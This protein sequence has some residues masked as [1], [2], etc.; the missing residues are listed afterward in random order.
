MEVEESPYVR[1]VESYRE[2]FRRQ[3]VQERNQ[4]IHV[5]EEEARIL[6]GRTARVQNT[7]TQYSWEQEVESYDHDQIG[8]EGGEEALPKYFTMPMELGQPLTGPLVGVIPPKAESG[9]EDETLYA[10]YGRT[11]YLVAPET[12]SS[13]SSSSSPAWSGCD[14]LWKIQKSSE[15]HLP[16][17]KGGWTAAEHDLFLQGLEMYGHD[18]P[19]I[20]ELLITRTAAQIRTY[21]QNYFGSFI[22]DTPRKEEQKDGTTTS[23]VMLLSNPF[24]TDPEPM[25]LPF[26]QVDRP[27]GK[28]EHQPS[29]DAE[30]TMRI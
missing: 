7:T 30:D 26:D 18:P 8:L 14:A 10:L 29:I 6:G 11:T 23:Q 20:S 22:Q 12:S 2:S 15:P 1:R 4:R 5:E 13:S 9:V 27:S 17:R 24:P 21:A 25:R 19:A 3:M 16:F 28:Q